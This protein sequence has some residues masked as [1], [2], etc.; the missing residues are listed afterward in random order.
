M[1]VDGCKT[2]SKGSSVKTKEILE[3][4]TLEAK[5]TLNEND[6]TVRIEPY[7]DF[8]TDTMMEGAQDVEERL[9]LGADGRDLRDRH[10]DVLGVVR[11]ER[12]ERL[13]EG[14]LRRPLQPRR[15]HRVGEEE[16]LAHRLAVDR[17]PARVARV[18]GA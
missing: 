6:I 12:G 10:R 17:Q 5:E 2:S 16:E 11:R 8:Y 7:N 15:V 13:R 9:R 4:M 1:S 18:E 3:M 14:E